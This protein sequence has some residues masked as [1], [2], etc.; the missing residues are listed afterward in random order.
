MRSGICKS[1]ITGIICLITS[2]CSK[3]GN[4]NPTFEAIVLGPG[5]DC[6]QYGIKFTSRLDEISAITGGQ[7]NDS[8]YAADN[9][10]EKLQVRGL[11]IRVAIRRINGNDLDR[12][13]TFNLSYLSVYILSAS[14]E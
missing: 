3:N 10:P 4:T 12:C 1:L 6:N 14:R 7:P 11:K 9:L 5:Y 13:I 2:S 8:I